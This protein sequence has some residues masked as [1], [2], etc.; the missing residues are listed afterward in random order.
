MYEVTLDATWELFD[1]FIEGERSGL[2]C[3]I[4]L[5]T[6]TEPARRALQSSCAALDYGK[7]ACTFVTLAER[8]DTSG[9]SLG[10]PDD[11]VRDNTANARQADDDSNDSAANAR[12]ADKEVGSTTSARQADECTGDLV[13]DAPSLFALVEGLDPLC[14]VA[15][16]STAAATLA[17][18]YRADVATNAAS[19]LLGRTVVAFRSFSSMLNDGQDKQVAWALLKKL[20]H[21]K[22]HA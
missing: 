9:E 18:A 17:K 16:D 2:F 20:P 6:L 1:S 5:R 13:L 14:V 21:A 12:Q 19:R 10:T 15:T 4:S 22:R 11:D 8:T 3:V 7:N